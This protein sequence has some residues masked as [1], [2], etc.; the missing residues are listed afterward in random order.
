[1]LHRL[2]PY[3][4]LLVSVDQLVNVQ[5]IK[6]VWAICKDAWGCWCLC[7]RLL[8]QRLP[9]LQSAHM[10]IV[11]TAAP[12]TLCERKSFKRYLA[13]QQPC[14]DICSKTALSPAQ[15]V[16]A[17]LTEPFASVLRCPEV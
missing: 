8:C 7:T 2:L 14:I 4:L 9:N 10:T 6:T 15:S 1:M 12:L 11:L 5:V 17:V 16:V 13:W 3:C